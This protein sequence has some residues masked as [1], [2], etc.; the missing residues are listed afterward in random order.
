MLC[1]NN[2]ELALRM[3]NNNNNSI[4]N[5][6]NITNDRI[7]SINR[8]EAVHPIDCFSRNRLHSHRHRQLTHLVT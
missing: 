3:A 6:N 2:I 5:R 1:Y 4:N 7:D 8:Y